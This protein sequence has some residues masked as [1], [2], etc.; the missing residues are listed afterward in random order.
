MGIS[1]KMSKF[2]NTVVINRV[3]Y[4]YNGSSIEI[5]NGI[6]KLNGKKSVNY[7]DNGTTL[8]IVINGASPEIKIA[9]CNTLEVNGHVGIIQTSSGDVFVNGTVLDVITTSGDVRAEKIIGDVKTTSGDVTAK[10]IGGS[11]KTVSGD[12]NR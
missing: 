9:S 5:N 2:E 3:E 12:I 10:S 7:S 8:N 6:I 1:A 11:V 4:D